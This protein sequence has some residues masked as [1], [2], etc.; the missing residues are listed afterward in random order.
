MQASAQ[1]AGETAADGRECL[2]PSARRVD[3]GTVALS[4]VICYMRLIVTSCAILAPKHIIFKHRNSCSADQSPRRES[5]I[6]VL[7]A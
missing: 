4:K 1:E 6:R 2:R 3:V 5:L 7:P